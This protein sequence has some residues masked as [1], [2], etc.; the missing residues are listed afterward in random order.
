MA[1][2][3]FLLLFL[4][5]FV[6][7]GYVAVRHHRA[8][9]DAW[10]TAAQRLGMDFRPGGIFS[11]SEM[12]GRIDGLPVTV[13]TFSRG[14]G[15]NS[16]TWTAYNV[17]HPPLGPPV[18]LTRDNAVSS[19]FRRFTGGTDAVLGDPQLDDT[20]RIDTEHPDQLAEFLTPTRRAAVMT[21]FESWGAAK[22]THGD[23]TVSTKGRSKDA[24]QI[25]STLRRIVDTANVLAAPDRVDRALRLQHDG[26]LAAATEQLHQ[27]AEETPNTFVQLLEAENATAID[28]ERAATVLEDLAAA[29]P[30][31]PLVN[32]WAEVAAQPVPGHTA[33]G[34]AGVIG[35][36]QLQQVIDDLFG[37]DRRGSEIERHFEATYAGRSV[38]WSGEV[39]SVRPYRVD[40]DFGATPGTKVGITLGE[41]TPTR[42]GANRV[43]GVL[44][45]P[46]GVEPDRNRVISFTGKLAKVDRFTRKIFVADAQLD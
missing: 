18:T 36:D 10:T 23:I 29:L 40:A 30:G 22:I 35:A 12:H 26:D 11:K 41:T 28:H 16:E 14:S 3:L 20:L 21:I 13:W 31:D 6:T 39:E 15:E 2:A 5:I 24:D 32:D 9:T 43:D 46:E 45:L 37:A 7:I 27:I 25:V 19:F 4:G 1:G 33:A 42:F 8:A 34:D 17:T 44:S 38:R